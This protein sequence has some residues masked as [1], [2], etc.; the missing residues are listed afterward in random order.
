MPQYRK[1]NNENGSMLTQYIGEILSLLFFLI[2]FVLFVRMFLVSP[3]RVNGA[4]MEPTFIDNQ[5]F[6]VNRLVYLFNDPKRL[7]VVELLN[8]DEDTKVIKRIIG[9][10]GE[11]LQIKRGGVYIKRKNDE[12]F[13]RLSEVEYLPIGEYTKIEKQEGIFEMKLYDNQYFVLGDNRDLSTDSRNY[14]PIF[15]SYIVGRVNK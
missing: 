1:T 5:F 9:L 3:G 6:V 15:R 12:D 8:R 11:T 10:P 13:W 7:D 14:G 4:S 2:S